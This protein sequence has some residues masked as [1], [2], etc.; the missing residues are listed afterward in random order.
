MKSHQAIGFAS[1]FYTL[2]TIS[3]EDTYVVDCHGRSR[4]SGQRV[5]YWYHK[6]VSKDVEK[7]KA[8]YPD[9]EICEDLRGKTTSWSKTLEVD[10][11]PE[12]MKFGK[13]MGHDLNELVESDF[14]YVLWI[15]EN[16]SYTSNGEYAAQIDKVKTFLQ[17][18]R[19]AE[20]AA[21]LKRENAF[22]AF[23]ESGKCEFVADSNLKGGGYYPYAYLPFQ[24]SDDITAYLMF[25]NYKTQYFKGCAYSLPVI[26]GAAKKIKG[27][28]V[29][30]SFE[31]RP[32]TSAW[33]YEVWVTDVKI[34]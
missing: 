6:N 23:V 26:K 4:V 17:E 33:M 14:D 29:T 1:Q 21:I 13:Y 5:N 8:L 19:D 7:V 10:L 28:T 27:K 9:L 15:V 34:S 3:V 25:S 32:E 22:K 24:I 20:N 11:C 18:K 12:V 30:V 31:K 16:K 2:W